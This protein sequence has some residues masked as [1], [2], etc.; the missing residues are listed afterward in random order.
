MIGER[1]KNIIAIYPPYQEKYDD[2]VR[3]C[4]EQIDTISIKCETAQN[5]TLVLYLSKKLQYQVDKHLH[6]ITETNN[7]YQDECKREVE[8]IMETNS[9]YTKSIK[10]FIV[11]IL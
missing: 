10:Y 7:R 9:Y 1:I 3:Q 11:L 5:K 2:L 8:S 4:T 6:L